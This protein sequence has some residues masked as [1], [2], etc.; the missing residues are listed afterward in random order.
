MV[1]TSSVAAALAV[2]PSKDDAPRVIQ[3]FTSVFLVSRIG[4]LWRVYDTDDPQ[5][6]ERQMP[7]SLSTA[8]HRVFFALA[9][10]TQFRVFTFAPGASRELDPVSL[11]AQL[12]ASALR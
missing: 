10:K 11:Q 12:D 7:T 5:V 9:R 3:Q 8:P 6:G 2:L 1:G 4:E